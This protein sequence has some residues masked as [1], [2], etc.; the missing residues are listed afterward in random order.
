MPLSNFN[1]AQRYRLLSCH[2]HSFGEPVRYIV[3]QGDVRDVSTN[4]R[5]HYRKVICGSVSRALV[6]VSLSCYPTVAP[7]VSQLWK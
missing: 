6:Q 4:V 2:G 3:L 7:I 5:C 1:L